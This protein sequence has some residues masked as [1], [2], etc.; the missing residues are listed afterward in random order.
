MKFRP[1]CSDQLKKSTKIEPSA[2]IHK[3]TVSLYTIMYIS[4]RVDT[5]HFFHTSL[6]QCLVFLGI[7]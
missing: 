7:L 4:S 3:G 1:F 6:A 5:G 2:D